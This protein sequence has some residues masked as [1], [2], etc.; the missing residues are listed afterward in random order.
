MVGFSGFFSPLSLT[1]VMDCARSWL[2][3]SARS[4]PVR[5]HFLKIYQADHIWIHG[6]NDRLRQHLEELEQPGELLV[7]S[8]R[9]GDGVNG[10]RPCTHKVWCLKTAVR[11]GERIFG[12][13]IHRQSCVHVSKIDH[14]SRL[15]SA[16]EASRHLLTEI[17]DH[18]LELHDR[19]FRE[20]WIQ[21]CPS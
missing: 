20:K 8:T 4:M 14:L 9:L 18:R 5:T 16:T 7:D 21:W 19:S 15:L 1:L 2:V 11:F 13:D 3:S 12:D 6:R 10:I 17:S